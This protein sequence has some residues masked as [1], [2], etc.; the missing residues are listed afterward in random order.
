MVKIS[1][2][3]FLSIVFLLPIS[4]L[5]Q[6][7]KL[8][9]GYMFNGLL[10]NPAY[11]GSQECLNINAIVKKQWIGMQGSPTSMILSGHTPIKNEKVAVGIKIYNDQLG[12]TRHTGVH[13]VYAYRIKLNESLKLS[14][15]IDAGVINISSNFASL[16]SKTDGD[17]AFSQ[18]FN[19]YIADFSAGLYLQNENYFAGIS[20]PHL[21]RNFINKT[22]YKGNSIRKQYFITGGYLLTLRDNLKFRPTTLVRFIEGAQVQAD[23]NAHFILQDVLWIGGSYRTAGAVVFLTQMQI[24]PQ[25]NIGYGFDTNIRMVNAGKASS[26]EIMLNYR[27][28]FFNSNLSTPR[29]F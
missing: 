17:I 3:L 25:L 12:V 29:Y 4:S 9:S 10:I 2:L 13:G 15:G 6:N 18:N 24:S 22:G 23:L 8:F 28:A 19:S 1:K 5:A 7:D 11:A 20:I 26:H 21:Q 16:A 14:A 27:F